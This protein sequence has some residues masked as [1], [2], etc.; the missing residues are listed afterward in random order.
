MSSTTEE[1]S[2]KEWFG[3]IVQKDKLTQEK[4]AA[5][6]DEWVHREGAATTSLG[7]KMVDALREVQS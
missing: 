6:G 1:K 4:P 3:L 7:D 5:R 2:F